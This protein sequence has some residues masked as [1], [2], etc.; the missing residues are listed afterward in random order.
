MAHSRFRKSKRARKNAKRP[1]RFTRVRTL[2][3]KG[4]RTGTTFTSRSPIPKSQ[5]VTFSFDDETQIDAASAFATASTNYFANALF[6]PQ[7]SFAGSVRGLLEYG[8][9]YRQYEVLSSSLR[10]TFYSV[11]GQNLG[12]V[13]VVGA[14]QFSN[15]QGINDVLEMPHVRSKYLNDIVITGTGPS[16]ITASWDKSMYRKGT[17]AASKV[18]LI[19]SNPAA[20]PFFEIGTGNMAFL[21]NPGPVNVRIHMNMRAR[22]FDAKTL[23]TE[24]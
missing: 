17:P 9:L 2:R 23:F 13:T 22:L 4:R 6:E 18:A 8:G 5:I 7:P 1:R 11:Q 10:A 3:K 15:V 21:T 14:G 19:G 16:V 24:S 20:L 12:Y